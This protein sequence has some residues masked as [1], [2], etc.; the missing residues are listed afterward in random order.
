MDINYIITKIA[1][2]SIFEK[3]SEEHIINRQYFLNNYSLLNDI[4]ASFVTLHKSDGN[5]EKH[6]RG[7]I[8]TLYPHRSLF[9]DII[10]NAKSAAFNDPRFDPVSFDELEYIT[11]EVSVLSEPAIISYKD[12][13]D[14]KAKIIPLKHG[15]II[16]KAFN[17]AVFLPDVWDKLPD[18]YQFFEHLCKKAGLSI[19]CLN[20]LDQVELFEVTKYSEPT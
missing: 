20:S 7:C 13:E 6:L 3:L 2:E 14:L 16:K 8:G 18:F 19:N 5:N 1:R 17:R 11:I 4:R 10:N 12:I 9:E 15:V